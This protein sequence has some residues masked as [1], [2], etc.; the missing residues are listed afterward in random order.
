MRSDRSTLLTVA[1][2]SL[3]ACIAVA[4]ALLATLDRS[5]QTFPTARTAV[6]V[7]DVP[8]GVDLQRLLRVRAVHD[9]VD[10]YRVQSDPEHVGRRNVAAV[11]GDRVAAA[12]VFDRDGR[13][14]G[15]AVE[16]PTVLVRAHRSER[17]VYFS[18]MSVEQASA[19]VSELRSAGVEAR[20]DPAGWWTAITFTVGRPGVGLA[21]GAS[22]VA[23]ALLGRLRGVSVAR[24]LAVAEVL[25][26]PRVRRAETARVL[27]VQSVVALAAAVAASV[28]ASAAV[29]PRFPA[30]L[31]IAGT[32]HSA[33]AGLFLVAMVSA[34]RG[35]GATRMRAAWSSWRPWGRVALPTAALRVAAVVSIA[36]AVGP[37]AD[38]VVLLGQYHRAAETRIDCADCT[39]PLLSGT[40]RPDEIEA[41]APAFERLFR[42]VDDGRSVLASHPVV[43]VEQSVEP[44]VGNTLV[45]NREYLR[46]VGQPFSDPWP[47]RSTVDAGQWALFV[48]T[49]SGVPVDVVLE[50]W[51]AWFAFQREIDPTLAE[52]GEPSVLEYS[53][54][55][56]FTF[57]A[58]TDEAPLFADAPVV[59][60]VPAA[61]RLL[62]GDFLTAAASNGQFLVDAADPR[63]LVASAGLQD[64]VGPLHRWQDVLGS[65]REDLL[66]TALTEAVA[67]AV[68][69]AVTVMAVSV[70]LRAF[71]WSDTARVREAVR[72]GVHP[73]RVHARMLL[74]EGLVVAATVV[75][76]ATAA[77]GLGIGTL[78]TVSAA[79]VV[80]C[81]T[82]VAVWVLLRTTGSEGDEDAV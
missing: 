34:W 56:V 73:V 11:I 32:V 39:T 38:S 9:H 66:R 81:G 48:P 60:V 79:A 7:L 22:G 4:V 36:L 61:A 49:D 76:A 40:L 5:D 58:A 69:S 28:L 29:G 43:P 18:T 2:M 6:V 8:E 68:A 47:G 75:V 46:R 50:R 54:Q 45:V 25:G 19:F 77:E 27:G 65:H 82:T 37:L 20:V 53:P 3:A 30:V 33:Q 21:I 1:A 57:G 80:A 74:A 63:R 51:R 24:R 62:S 44:D 64:V 17:G 59:A 70:R 14:R 41:A 16:Q 71:R 35:S 55:E 52:P 13:Y 26:V 15:G 12:R 42:T 78:P 23:V 67:A 10:F 72:L 31:V